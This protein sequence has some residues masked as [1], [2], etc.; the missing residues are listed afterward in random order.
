MKK[1]TIILPFALF[2]LISCTGKS[3]GDIR[4][5]YGS[6]DDCHRTGKVRGLLCSRCNITIGRFE[7]EPSIIR[8]A[9]EYLEKKEYK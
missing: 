9:A 2:T 4:N 3:E 6:E 7:D 8:S 5:Q 1:R